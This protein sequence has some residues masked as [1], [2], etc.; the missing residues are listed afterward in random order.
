MR[1]TILHFTV[2]KKISSV[3][4][5]WFTE[6]PLGGCDS[7]QYVSDSPLQSRLT[8]RQLYLECVNPGELNVVSAEI[9]QET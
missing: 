9:Q 3:N 6:K 4:Q 1:S 2:A 5:R 7:Q 8:L